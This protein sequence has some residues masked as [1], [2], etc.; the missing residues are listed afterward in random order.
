MDIGP[1]STIVDTAAHKII[2]IN[3]ATRT[4]STSAYSPGAMAGQVQ[5]SIKDTGQTKTILGHPARHYLMSMTSARM[6]SGRISGDVWSAQDLPQPPAAAFSGG[7]AAALQGQFRKI[8]GMPLIV[9]MVVTGSPVGDTSIRSVTKSVSRAPLSAS[10]FADP[11][12]LHAHRRPQTPGGM[13][14]GQ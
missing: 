12:G 11:G 10:L 7:P 8:K 9:N 2:S 6:P 13:P 1:L 4:Y 3:R 14:M 5:A